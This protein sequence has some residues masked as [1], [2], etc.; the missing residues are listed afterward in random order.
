MNDPNFVYQQQLQWK[1]KSSLNN[2]GEEQT[3][4]ENAVVTSP[5]PP[6]AAQQLIFD[7]QRVKQISSG[8]EKRLKL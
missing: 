1:T 6:A 4:G 3:S 2:P 5:V 8:S 7:S